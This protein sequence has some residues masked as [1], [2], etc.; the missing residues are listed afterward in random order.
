MGRTGQCEH[1]PKAQ[2]I[3]GALHQGLGVKSED[4]F[5]ENSLF[6]EKCLPFKINSGQFC[7]KNFVFPLVNGLWLLKRETNA[8]KNFTV[9]GESWD[10]FANACLLYKHLRYRA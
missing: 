8:I 4:P 6:R 2:R 5:R 10:V 9:V 3:I 1:A 7:V